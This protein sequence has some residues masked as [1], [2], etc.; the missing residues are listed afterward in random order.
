[1]RFPEFHYRWHW[2]LTSSPERL[3]PLV[4]DTNRFNR[5]TGLPTVQRLGEERGSA[6]QR[7]GFRQFGVR[8]EW[9]EEPFEW[10]RPR[11]FGVV[12]RY[13]T[14]PVASMRVLA[15]LAPEQGAGTHLR[16]ET[17][18]RPR[19]LPGLFAVCFGML[20]V[21]HRLF[22]ATF[23]R[24]DQLAAHTG[25]AARDTSDT[26]DLAPGATARLAEIERR[27][28]AETGMPE[29]AARLIATVA[30]SDDMA[31]ARLRPYALA[32]SWDAPRRDVLELC[33]RA[34]RLGLFDLQW[35]VLCPLCRGV[36]EAIPRL[37]ALNQQVHCETCNIDFTANFDRSVELTFC[38]SPAIR[39]VEHREFCVGGPQVTPHIIA[40]QLLPRGARRDLTLPLEPGRYRV[41][42]L[43]H[44]GNALLVAAADGVPEMA[45]A[46]AGNTWPEGEQRI[47]LAP[48]LHLANENDTER[49]YILERTLWTDQA[50][51]AAEVTTLQIFRDLFGTELLRP[52]EQISVGNLTILF[53]D[54]RDSTSLY[55]RIGD[56]PAFARVMD[57]FDVLR[58]AIEAEDGA[59]VKTIGDAVMAVFRRPAAALRAILRAQPQLARP[60]GDALPLTIKA[61]LYHGHCIAVTANER[62]DYF[63]STVNIAA[64]L[65]RLSSGTDV[66]ISDSVRE[67]PE[68]AEFLAAADG[69]IAIERFAAVLKGLDEEQF[70]L[71]RVAQAKGADALP[72]T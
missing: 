49:L 3:W 20:F 50:T 36:K 7:L 71:W 43:G 13:R 28:A 27:L 45:I 10:V 51:T 1:M 23:R 48:T 67:D 17:W 6:R 37:G 8:V 32:D 58:A 5:D 72:R 2:Q 68:V 62:L 16:Y 39:A 21:T 63:G 9:E 55:R 42:A 41:R 60:P 22:G 44:G 47:S 54:L 40:Q 64:R 18:V 38:P 24:Y 46:C 26:V 14:G 61:G 29:L 52:G 15:E 35:D 12:R 70:H 65:E 59:I 66:I 4:S 69:A 30:Q 56:A 57:H 31:V 11:R 25:I 34:T 33:L 53:T 19:T